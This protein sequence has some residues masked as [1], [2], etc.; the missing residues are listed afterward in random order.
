VKQ[1]RRRIAEIGGLAMSKTKKWLRETD[2]AEEAID[3]VMERIL[4]RDGR[5]AYEDASGDFLTGYCNT[6]VAMDGGPK[7]LLGMLRRLER[8]YS[9]RDGAKIANDVAAG[10]VDRITI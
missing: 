8:M 7:R 5:R 1:R 10:L 9:K 3:E 2:K 6:I 4:E